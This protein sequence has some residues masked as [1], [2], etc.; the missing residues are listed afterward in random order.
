MFVNI[1]K[2]HHKDFCFVKFLIFFPGVLPNQLT[3]TTGFVN[4]STVYPKKV[5]YGDCFPF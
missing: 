1:M 4:V 3:S 5:I 2:I